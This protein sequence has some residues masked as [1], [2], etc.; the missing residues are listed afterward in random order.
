MGD[1]TDL[2]RGG[3][4]RCRNDVYFIEEKIHLHGSHGRHRGGEGTGAPRLPSSAR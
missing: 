4:S 3:I 2:N 1:P